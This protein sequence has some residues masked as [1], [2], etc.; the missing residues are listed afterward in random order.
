MENPNPEKVA[1]VDEVVGKLR[2]AQA[3][4]VTEY[5]GLSVGEL[6]ELRTELR[7][8]G[9]EYRVYKNT[10]VRLA[11]AEAGVDI[12]ELLV[13][14]TAIAFVAPTGD[15]GGDPVLAAKAMT[16]FAKTYPDLVL[17]GGVLGDT[18]LSADEAEA[19]SKV[20]PR[21][22]LLA[23]FAGG[24]AAPMRTLAGLLQ[25]VP[26]DFA[27]GLQALIE[28]GGAGDA[29]APAA[30]ADAD[31]PTDQTTEPVESPDTTTESDATNDTQE[32][33]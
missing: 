15:D 18:V 30:D 17:K 16:K 28:K 27:Y 21:E 7:K 9:T 29:P 31:A 19:L 13:G 24:L 32:E 26:R 4:L 10:L 2:E 3:L 33:S 22:E 1:V 25:A 11:A 12:G 20:A 14:P 8:A 6:S 23:R 5:R